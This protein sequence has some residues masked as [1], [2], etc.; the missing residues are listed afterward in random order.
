MATGP[1]IP[2]FA[3]PE[4]P[5][6]VRIT[7][8]ATAATWILFANP[9]AVA[10]WG[11]LV[12]VITAVVFTRPLRVGH[13]GW[14]GI[15]LVVVVYGVVVALG[16]FEVHVT[17]GRWFNRLVHGKPRF[18]PITSPGRRA[19]ATILGCIGF[20]EL[21][22]KPEDEVVV[23]KLAK[24][25]AA[26]RKELY[27]I[28]YLQHYGEEDWEAT[29]E[30]MQRVEYHG[31]RF[32]EATQSGLFELFGTRF[33]FV[34]RLVRPLYAVFWIGYLWFLADAIRG[35]SVV[36]LVQFTLLGGFAI[37][38]Q[39]FACFTVSFRAVSV[40]TEASLAF[41]GEESQTAR[42]QDPAFGHWMERLLSGEWRENLKVHEGD[43]LLPA[44][45]IREGYIQTVRNAFVREWVAVGIL[46]GAIVFL[47]L[48]LAIWPIALAVDNW[49]DAAVNR[50]SVYWLIGIAAAPL[51]F[52]VLIGVGFFVLA[53]LRALAALVA[54]GLFLALVPPL[55]GLAFNKEVDAAV[56]VSSIIA[57][58][59]GI[60]STAMAE[61]VRK[62]PTAATIT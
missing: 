30:R 11:I 57:S 42:D 37:A 28:R 7:G 54:T 55:V 24:S 45:G 31:V 2:D 60:V 49:K 53:R 1:G 5:L 18:W 32:G 13:A 47:P 34:G 21:R 26:A 16:L 41:F 23:N 35:G 19:M 51:V 12:G 38:A 36:R 6:S 56:V 25:T 58:L 62:R 59:A 27:H 8:I 44:V 43:T 50:W 4:Q 3:A 22:W 52:S 33:Q 14:V 9:V 10:V 46:D 15:V 17:R 39:I 61:L 29:W 20:M 40:R 48:I